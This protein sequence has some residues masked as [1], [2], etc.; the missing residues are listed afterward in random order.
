MGTVTII[1]PSAVY[2]NTIGSGGGVSGNPGGS[3]S[4]LQFNDNG[5]FGGANNFTYDK[6]T[7]MIMFNGDLKLYNSNKEWSLNANT[8]FTANI[9]NGTNTVYSINH[10]INKN[11]IITI[12]TEN[13]TGNTVYPDIKNNSNY[14]IVSFT[15][16]P[17]ANQYNITIIG[18]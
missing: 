18:I 13:A 16:A 9:G 15:A 11:N 7:G 5:I 17:T 14:T 1:N 12:V 10:N 2:S 8:K 4:Q 3:S 6:T